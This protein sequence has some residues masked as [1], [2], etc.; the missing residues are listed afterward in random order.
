MLDHKKI[1][2]VAVVA[3][4]LL[5]VLGVKI[6]GT[7][8]AGTS[9]VLAVVE[10]GTVVS[11]VSGTGQASTA[12]TLA[13][14]P[15]VSGTIR[16]IRAKPGDS[17]RKGQVL[18]T[19]DATDAAKTL[20]DA[21][22]GLDSARLALASF[23]ASTSSTRNDQTVAVDTAFRSLLNTDPSAVAADMNTATFTSPEITGNY[24]LDREGSIFVTTYSSNGGLSFESKGLV[25]AVGLVSSVTPQP[26]GSSGLF[27]TFPAKISSGLSWT[28]TLPNKNAPGYLANYNAY[29]QALRSRSE[30]TASGSVN[31]I[32]LQ[33]KRLAV[34]QAE[35]AV[36]DAQSNLSKY[37]VTAPFDGILAS[38]P[39]TEGQQA[40]GATTLGTIITDQQVATI[41]LNE[42]DAAKVS[43]GQKAT[44]SFDAIDGLTITGKVVQIDTLGT[45]SQGVVNY[46]VKIAFDTEDPRVKSGMSASASIATGVAQDVLTV[47]ISAVKGSGDGTYVLVAAS[48]TDTSP[49]Q[50]PVTTGLSDDTNT[51]ITSGLSE[52]TLV[53]R[54]TVTATATKTA[55]PSILSS[56]GGGRP[57]GTGAARTG[58]T[59]SQ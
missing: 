6:F 4:V 44:L 53:V 19:I 57:G 37:Y 42:V 36:A 5:V 21:K 29:Q 54:K 33:T 3:T 40:S 39:V 41:P 16:S 12:A 30:S 1:S 59:V 32:G 22:L 52:G 47:P 45:V 14:T 49:V 51:E 34:T 24:V 26:I 48:E 7:T 27:I 28:I 35:N 55:A 10:K 50:T 38:I 15:Q 11:T 58:G 18:F 43:I 25:E 13:L 17:V 2:V 56:I 8:D 9:Y 31:D 46:S 20:R 23:E